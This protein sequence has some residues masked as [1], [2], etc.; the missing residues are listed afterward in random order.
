MSRADTLLS[1][2]LFAMPTDD[3]T[4]A[5]TVSIGHSFDFLVG[6]RA[7]ACHFLLTFHPPVYSRSCTAPIY[8]CHLVYGILNKNSQILKLIGTFLIYNRK[9]HTIDDGSKVVE[10]E[11]T[12]TILAGDFSVTPLGRIFKER[13]WHYHALL[14]PPYLPN[15]LMA[16]GSS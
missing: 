11:L 6:V 13:T 1:N 3:W 8:R 7:G 5:L 4:F 2:T 14:V 9:V 10:K 15:F 16:T 12:M